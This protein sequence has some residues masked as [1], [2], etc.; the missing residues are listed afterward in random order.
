MKFAKVFCLLASVLSIVLVS[1]VRAKPMNPFPYL[2]VW[3]S[4]PKG[5]CS[6]YQGTNYFTFSVQSAAGATPLTLS[7]NQPGVDDKLTAAILP[8]NG[9]FIDPQNQWFGAPTVNK[10][11]AASNFSQVINNGTMTAGLVRC[12]IVSGA[13]STSNPQAGAPT[14]LE[15]IVLPESYGL[16]PYLGPSSPKLVPQF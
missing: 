7:N 2:N 9:A 16:T 3:N 6:A 4:F 10:G 15:Y 11:P 13:V 8:L 14:H 1:E 5:N 12:R